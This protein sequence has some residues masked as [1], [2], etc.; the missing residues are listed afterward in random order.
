MLVVIFVNSLG[1]GNTLVV[2]RLWLLAGNK[3]NCMCFD[4]DGALPN[5]SSTSIR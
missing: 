5:I 4:I 3:G 1:G 2:N